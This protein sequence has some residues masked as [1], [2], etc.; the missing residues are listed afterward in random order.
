MFSIQICYV[1]AASSGIAIG[2]ILMSN[3]GIINRITLSEI[4]KINGNWHLPR[5]YEMIVSNIQLIADSLHGVHSSRL[6]SILWAFVGAATLFNV[7]VAILGWRSVAAVRGIA[8]HGLLVLYYCAAAVF[9]TLLLLWILHWLNFWIFLVLFVVIEVRR[10]E[11][12]G[13]R[14]SF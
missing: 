2:L 3:A 12:S 6:M 5:A 8:V 13:A 11:E 10:R 7:V 14:L 4:W 1:L 9:V